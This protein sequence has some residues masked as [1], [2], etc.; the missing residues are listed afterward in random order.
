[1]F[2]F[3]GFMIGKTIEEITIGDSTSQTVLVTEQN[4]HTFGHITKDLNPIHF[5]PDYAAT[6]IFKAPI[7]HG[8][9]VASFLVNCSV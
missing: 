1:M 4:V 2:Q 6:T 9:Y 8:M 3:G 7:S 5:D